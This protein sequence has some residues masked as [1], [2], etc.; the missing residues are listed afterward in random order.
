[1]D[2]NGCDAN[3]AQS[4]SV[5][6]WNLNRYDGDAGHGPSDSVDPWNLSQDLPSCLRILEFLIER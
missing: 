3:H 1:M 4:D 2:S 5:D 6:P